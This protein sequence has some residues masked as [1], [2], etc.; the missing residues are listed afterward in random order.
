MKNIFLSIL[1]IFFS[2][3]LYGQNSAY[4]KKIYEDYGTWVVK[5]DNNC[6]SISA[7]CTVENEDT[8][9][10]INQ[11]DYKTQY[12]YE[13]YLVSKSIY[14]SNKT[15]TWLYGTKIYID[16]KNILENQFPDGFVILIKTK[17]TLIY[18]Y[19]SIENN[20][21]FE[22]KWDKSIYEIKNNINGK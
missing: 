22:I 19:H 12:K 13:V 3:S 15:N 17:P 14:D 21:K 18:T 10:K 1:I 6:I 16:G 9:I 20:V 2:I 11:S 5:N 8:I 4:G 7:F